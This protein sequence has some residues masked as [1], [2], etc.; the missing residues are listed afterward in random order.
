MKLASLALAVSLIGMLSTSVQAIQCNSNYTVQRGD[1][2]SKIAKQVYGRTS[3]Y[4]AIFDYNPGVLE[5]PN[6][7]PIGVTLYIPCKKNI[8]NPLPEFI[9]SKTGDLK[10]L[11]GSE[12]PPYVDAGLPNGGFSFE[13]VERAMQRGSEK[14]NYQ[15]DVI[16]DWGSHLKTLLAGG[17]YELAFPWFK[18]DCTN[19]KSL[20]DSSKWRCNNLRFSEPLHE[21]VVTFYTTSANA[22]QYKSATDLNNTIICRPRGY[23]THDLESMGLTPPRIVRVA[24]DSPKDC[25]ER[26]VEGEVNIVTLN[27]DTSDQMITELGIRDKVTELIDL[28]SIQTLHVV[29]MK[30]NPRTRP[31]MLRLNKGLKDLQRS[32]DFI[33]IAARHLSQQ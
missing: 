20:G 7:L 31:N 16:N 27:A 17:A 13:V 10:I 15:V 28:A 8:V 14:T 21:V 24:G 22:A 2:L 4:Q 23:F 5:A 11:T 32:G 30:S 18:P 12:Y 6:V 3:A 1:S 19:T 25:F 26:L 29:G 9:T 33:K